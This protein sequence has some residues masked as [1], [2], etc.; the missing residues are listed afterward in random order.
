MSPLPEVLIDRWQNRHDTSDPDDG[1]VYWHVLLGHQEPLRRAAQLGQDR[2]AE[3]PGLHMTPLEW[4]HM[5]VLV[6]GSVRDI[7]EDDRL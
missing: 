4:L 5:T 6:A 3:F 1:L 2:L 7:S